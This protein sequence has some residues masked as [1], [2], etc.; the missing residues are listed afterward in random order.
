MAIPLTKLLGIF[1]ASKVRKERTT[2][3][4]LTN[5]SKRYQ[6]AFAFSTFTYNVEAEQGDQS[7]KLHTKLTNTP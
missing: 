5:C 6:I 1:C 7:N 3:R 2:C 4:K